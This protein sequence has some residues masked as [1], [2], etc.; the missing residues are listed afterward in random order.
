MLLREAMT[1][2]TLSRYGVV[3]IDEAHERTLQTDFLL[4]TLK[5]VQAQRRGSKRPLKLVVMSATLEADSF[6]RFFDGAPVVYSQGRKYP[7]ETFYTEAP[8]DDYL[9]AAMCAVCQINEEEDEG[10]VLVFLTGQEEIES[11]GQLLRRRSRHVPE[12]KP[13]LNVVLLFAAMPPE[14]QMRVFEPSPPGTRKIVLATN[15]A[16]T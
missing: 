1:D 2:A 16:E 14:E 13:K 6:S 8:E 3:M 4:G 11:L 5:K 12:G 9:D 7:V 15:I 10:D